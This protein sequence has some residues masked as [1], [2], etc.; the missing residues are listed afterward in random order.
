MLNS[1]ITAL[2]QITLNR[3]AFKFLLN[4]LHVSLKVLHGLYF[5]IIDSQ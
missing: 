2:L 1:T 3:E 4:L 5:I